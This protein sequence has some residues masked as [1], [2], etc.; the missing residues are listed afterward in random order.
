VTTETLTQNRTLSRRNALF[1]VY[2]VLVAIVAF[3]PLRKVV[4]LSLNPDNGDLSYINLIP[5]I[6]AAFIYWDRRRIFGESKSSGMAAG[7]VFVLGALFFLIGR[8][9]AIALG[10]NN[11]LSLITAAVVTLFFAG[12]LFFYGSA[13]FKTA[14]F[15]LLFLA[16][17][18]PIPSHI[19]E[20]M[21]TFL[22]HGSAAVTNVLFTLAG[23]PVYQV[24]MKFVLPKVTIVIAEECSGIRSTIGILIVTLLASR[25]LLRS[26]WS[27]LVLL[28]TVVPISLIK[29]A[30]R[31]V[32]LTLLAV[33]VDMGFLTGRL[34][35]EGG[36]VFMMIGLALIYPL[37]SLL[38][39]FERKDLYSGVQ[40]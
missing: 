2:C 17:A 25:L 6:S 34:H 3:E 9:N 4:E 39:R 37:L 8:T 33:H 12:F 21:V 26:N 20:A 31:I 29:N 40:S 10:A 30:I 23:T 18:I 38:I 13:S 14:L 11:N 19:L 28:L 22:Q 36:I 16:L 5:F 27:R 35:H 32:T 15:P 7:I 24:D 1:G